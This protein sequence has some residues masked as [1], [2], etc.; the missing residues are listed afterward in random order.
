MADTIVVSGTTPASTEETLTN[1]AKDEGKGRKTVLVFP[2]HNTYIV[3]DATPKISEKF[4]TKITG[5]TV[6]SGVRISDHLIPE[7]TVLSIDGVISDGGFLGLSTRGSTFLKNITNSVNGILGSATDNSSTRSSLEATKLINA[8]LG[9]IQDENSSTIKKST[10]VTVIFSNRA[11]SNCYFTN[12]TIDR[13]KDVYRATKF[14][15]TIEQVRKVILKKSTIDSTK[16][17]AEIVKSLSPDSDSGKVS[18]TTAP[19]NS[20]AKDWAESSGARDKLSAFMS[21][22]TGKG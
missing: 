20:L 3:L 22:I 14:S 8:I 9:I 17:S 11:Y 21:F 18:P 15:A 19:S 12:L 1:K 5:H 2:E 16:S 6:D 7:N 4:S 10:S 13:D